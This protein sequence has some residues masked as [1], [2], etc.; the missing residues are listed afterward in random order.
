MLSLVA[1]RG[2]AWLAAREVAM[3][4]FAES[5]QLWSHL[6]VHAG[7]ET[8]SQ[9][10]VKMALDESMRTPQQGEK[11]RCSSKDNPQKLVK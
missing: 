4:G 8:G 1:T 9:K 6:Q 5:V 10:A 11:P 3:P 7:H 2:K